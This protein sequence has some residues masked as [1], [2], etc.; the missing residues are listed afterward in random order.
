MSRP[1]APEFELLES[2]KNAFLATL[3]SWSSGDLRVR[4]TPGVWSALDVLDHIAKTQAEAFAGMQENHD[5]PIRVSLP[6]RLRGTFIIQFMR[7]PLRV[8]VPASVAA[9][10][11]PDHSANFIALKRDWNHSQS[12]LKQ[13]LSNLKSDP[14]SLTG[15]QHPVSGWMTVSLGLRFLA[16]H[17]RHHR[18]QLGRIK[19]QLAQ[20]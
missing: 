14:H 12:Q 17:V 19:R 9:A 20:N 5:Q 7:T 6:D 2:Q 16:A 1:I 11:L 3:D 10:V 15:F 13:W 4:P 18:Y 8:R